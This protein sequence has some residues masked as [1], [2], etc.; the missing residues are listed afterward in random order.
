MKKSL[1]LSLA[2][3]SA[4][5]LSCGRPA[6]AEVG[7]L[8]EALDN[9]AWEASEWISVVDAPIAKGPAL[10]NYKSAPGSSWFLSTVTNGKR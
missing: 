8:T 3:F 4:A 5:L 7:T 1:L 9:S 2:V 6:P 10:D